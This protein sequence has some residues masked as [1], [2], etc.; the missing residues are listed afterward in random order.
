[1]RLTAVH[2]INA[3]VDFVF[4]EFTNFAGF[5][6][7]AQERELT[8]ERTDDLTDIGAGMGWH[9]SGMVRGKHRDIEINLDEL[10]ENDRAQYTSASGAMSGQMFFEFE[11][12]GADVTEVTFHVEPQAD[13]ISSRLILQ[14]IRLAQNSVEKRI[15]KSIRIF[16]EQIEA[17]YMA[18]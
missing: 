3:P 8:V 17:K 13:S 12:L 15:K 10:R 18:G 7:H 11:D 9:I 1:M 16:G 5:E 4:K 14:S 2:A 6:A